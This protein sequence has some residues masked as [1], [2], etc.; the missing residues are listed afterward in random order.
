[1]LISFCAGDSVL[2][3]VRYDL[4]MVTYLASDLLEPCGNGVWHKLLRA[5]VAL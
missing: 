2:F 4:G 5:S 3:S 1:M